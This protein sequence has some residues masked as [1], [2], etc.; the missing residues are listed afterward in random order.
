MKVRDI[1][2]VVIVGGGIT[3]F[4]A[5]ALLARKGCR[6][7]VA[8]GFPWEWWWKEEGT[9][10]LRNYS[11]ATIFGLPGNQLVTSLLI[12]LGLPLTAPDEGPVSF[13]TMEPGAQVVMS[14]HRVSLPPGR[15]EQ[16][17]ELL[18]EFPDRQAGIQGLYRQARLHAGVG[19]R[20]LSMARSRSRDRKDRRSALANRLSFLRGNLLGGDGKPAGLA[21]DEWAAEGDFRRYLELLV[22]LLAR[23]RT[24]ELSLG[25]ISR[26][27]SLAAEPTCMNEA[28]QRGLF[29]GLRRIFQ[30]AGGK[31]YE[32]TR[33]PEVVQTRKGDVHINV[34]GHHLIQGRW[35]ILDVPEEE[36]RGILGK[37][38]GKWGSRDALR[39]LAQISME[40]PVDS[41]PPGMGRHLI[42]DSE[43]GEE[44]LIITKSSPVGGRIVMEALT[45]VVPEAGEEDISVSIM[46]RI[47]N[48]FRFLPEDLDPGPVRRGF[49]PSCHGTRSLTDGLAFP[50]HLQSSVSWK[51]TGPFILVGRGDYLGA[52]LN[53]SLT[54]GREIALWVA[55]RIRK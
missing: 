14:G 55:P 41:L 36:T 31:I 46:R 54:D 3:G 8:T 33:R 7:A 6:V 1:Y 40:I 50:G 47:R 23:R 19:E 10:L 20:H 9:P 4:T 21:L 52:P 34:D 29:N 2:D 15:H 16:Q 28:G 44:P 48:L 43:T 17:R 38:A 35:M 11:G 18:R 37:R 51:R 24:E 12:E 22:F 30:K 25:D 32:S 49:F 26:Y 5:G 13:K 27:L 53:D 39:P 42:L 45:P